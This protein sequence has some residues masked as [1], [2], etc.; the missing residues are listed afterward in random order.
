M[1]QNPTLEQWNELIVDTMVD[2]R[3]LNLLEWIKK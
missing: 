2:Y 1:K 3:C